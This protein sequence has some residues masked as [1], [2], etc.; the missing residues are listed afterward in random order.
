MRAPPL[1]SADSTM[2]A[3][4]PVNGFQRTTR[5]VGLQGFVVADVQRAGERLDLQV[6][7]LRAPPRAPL[8]R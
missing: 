8:R 5:L 4:A 2:T 6:G 1:S 7:L 3:F